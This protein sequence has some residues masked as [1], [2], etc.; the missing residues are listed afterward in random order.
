MQAKYDRIM[1]IDRESS[2]ESIIKELLSDKPF[3]CKVEGCG[4]RYGSEGALGTHTKI[5]HPDAAI[6]GKKRASNSNAIFEE[7]DEAEENV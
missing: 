3:L 4:K 1:R 2:T 7:P 5:K 6:A